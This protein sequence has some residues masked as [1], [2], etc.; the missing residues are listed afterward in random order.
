[1]I[2]SLANLIVDH[3][4]AAVAM[5]TQ[6]TMRYIQ[7]EWN[8]SHEEPIDIA[9]LHK[10][11][12]DEHYGDLNEEQKSFVRLRRDEVRNAY[13]AMVCRLLLCEEMLRRNMVPDFQSYCSVFCPEGGDAPWMLHRAG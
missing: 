1:M 3:D 4:A 12:C 7:A 10:F 9:E 11:L 13:A 5:R 2:I 6:D 8:K